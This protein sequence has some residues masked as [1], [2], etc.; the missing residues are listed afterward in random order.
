MRVT[1]PVV[2]TEESSDMKHYL[3]Y[4]CLMG[5]FGVWGRY[6]LST[7]NA[8]AYLPWVMCHCCVCALTFATHDASTFDGSC[9]PPCVGNFECKH[10]R[11]SCDG[12]HVCVHELPPECARQCGIDNSYICA[13]LRWVVPNVYV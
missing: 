4:T 12:F 8:D 6:L 7:Y 9:F 10:Y 3:P 5:A 2:Y 11:H 1:L 13:Y